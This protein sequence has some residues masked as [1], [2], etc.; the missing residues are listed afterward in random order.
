MVTS[1]KRSV[2]VETQKSSSDQN[3]TDQNI[4]VQTDDQNTADQN[5]ADQT[6]DQNTSSDTDSDQQED[7]T[8]Y[9]LARD[10]VRRQIHPPVR[11]GQADMVSYA[12]VTADQLEHSESWTYREAISSEDKY[13]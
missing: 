12:L 11:F 7:L 10:R 13:H 4:T 3:T 9:S 5:A 8:D 6:D 1:V 2:E